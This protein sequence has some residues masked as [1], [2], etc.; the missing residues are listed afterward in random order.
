MFYCH[1][2]PVTCH[3]SPVTCHLSP[4]TC[5]LSPVTSHLSPVTCHLSPVT[6]YLSPV[7]CHLPHATGHLSPVTC[8]LS[9]V[10]WHLTTTRCSF[11]WSESSRRLGEETEGDLVKN[12]EW[13]K[14]F[15][16]TKNPQTFFFVFAQFKENPC[17]KK[18]PSLEKKIPH[19]GDKEF[20]RIVGPIQFTS[21]TNWT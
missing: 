13:K 11:S 18:T 4:V 21:F 19:T 1:L 20:L 10:T 2:S 5:H 16:F 8:H 17:L 3:L 12:R 6:C 7:T 9:P 14:R 15:F